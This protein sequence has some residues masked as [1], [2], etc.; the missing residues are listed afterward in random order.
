MISR[1]EYQRASG[2]V[3]AAERRPRYMRDVQ[4][5][6]R[7]KQ[8]HVHLRSSEPGQPRRPMAHCRDA[9]DPKKCKS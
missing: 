1:P 4:A 9:Q 5:L 2:S 7:H 6:Q 8:H 3:P